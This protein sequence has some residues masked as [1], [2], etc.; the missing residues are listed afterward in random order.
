MTR[1]VVEA[2]GGSRGNPG[3]A[4][5]GTVVKDADSGAVLTEIAEYLGTVSNN[6]AEYRGLLAG[7]RAAHDI[8]PQ[9]HIEVR[10]DS[11]LVVEQMSGRWKIKH[12]DMRTIALQSRD[13]HDPTLITY[14]WVPR[15]E[16][17]H[18]DRLVNEALD[19]AARGQSWAPDQQRPTV[20]E[21]EVEPAPAPVLVGWA[22][23]LANPT[24]LVLLRHGETRLTAEKRFSGAGDNPGLSDRGQVQAD[25]AA[26][27]LAR[28][29]FSIDAV[30]TSPLRRSRETA[31]IVAA[32]LGLDID[33][34]ADLR[35][36]DFGAWDGLTYLE[37]EERFPTELAA[38]LGST[39]VAPPGG[40]S[41]DAV[42][43]RV[44]AARDRIV[45]RHPGRTV[46]VV[47]HVTPI[48]LL[49]RSALDAPMAA[50]FRM[51]LDPASI[52]QVSWWEDG[53]ASL[54][55]FNDTS[56]LREQKP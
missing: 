46:L 8:D 10:M 11:K 3:P 41:F 19:L 16:N 52:T 44:R 5:Y 1:L 33:E 50:L 29:G 14:T 31:A 17:A 42:A 9:A 6:V 18:A 36:A 26:A 25:L 28:G 27:H 24:T 34:D 51:E 39:S 38:W 55:V 40:E 15:S 47:S 7:L 21:A 2:D 12:P 13:A 23:D 45:T 22:P 4:A 30:V 48:K 54:R 43:R 37:V 49:V 56:H 32:A 53:N 35:E 20:D